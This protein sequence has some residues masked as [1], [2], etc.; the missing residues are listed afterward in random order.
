MIFKHQPDSASR[1]CLERL[2]SH[3]TTAA[4]IECISGAAR[5][6]TRLDL[7]R[8]T[9]GMTEQKVKEVLGT[10]DIELAI[11]KKSFGGLREMAASSGYFPKE[12]L[13]SF[14]G[15]G[16]RMPRLSV[17]GWSDWTSYLASATFIGDKLM[18]ISYQ[19]LQKGAKRPTNKPVIVRTDFEAVQQGMN[20]DDVL[21]ILGTPTQALCAGEAGNFGIS[22]G[23]MHLTQ[24]DRILW[25]DGETYKAMVL[26]LNGRVLLRVWQ[27]REPDASKGTVQFQPAEVIRDPSARML[28]RADCAKLKRDMTEKRVIEILGPATADITHPAEA[29]FVDFANSM[30]DLQGNGKFP[31]S[32]V[33]C[34]SDFTT[35]DATLVFVNG[36]LSI[37]TFD[38]LSKKTGR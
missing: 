4:I 10:G 21:K 5:R 22:V 25:T 17:L 3:H 34:W 7:F 37:Y 15:L 13:D 14:E 29:A 24:M 38:D 31:R 8:L 6:I 35:Y 12:A 28:T 36:R 2:D 33:M 1:S 20:V 23:N 19:D 26:M 32:K 9:T 30:F 11:D 27:D 18:M 16:A